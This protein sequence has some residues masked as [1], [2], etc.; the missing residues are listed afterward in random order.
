MDRCLL[1]LAVAIFAAVEGPLVFGLRELRDPAPTTEDPAVSNDDSLMP[2]TAVAPLS[3]DTVAP[4]ATVQLAAFDGRQGRRLNVAASMQLPPSYGP[5]ASPSPLPS[6]PLPPSPVEGN[7]PSPLPSTPLPPT[8]GNFSPSPV[9]PAPSPIPPPPPSPVMNDEA[10][11]P[12]PIPPP[13]PSP[14]MNDEAPAPS[15]LP[16]S[17]YVKDTPFPSSPTP[18][19]PPPF[20]LDPSEEPSPPSPQA[21]SPPVQASPVPSP[22]E[23]SPEPASPPAPW[24]TVPPSPS[25]AP[26]PAPSYPPSYPSSYP[27][28]YSPSPVP[29][30]PPTSSHSPSPVP[31][32]SPDPSSNSS[33]PSPSPSSSDTPSASYSPSPSPPVAS[34]SPSDAPS[35]SD[36]PFPSPSPSSPTSVLSNAP[37]C[38][39]DGTAATC[40]KTNATTGTI[41][42]AYLL[43]AS[44]WQ[45]VSSSYP[46]LLYEF[47]VISIIGSN[48]TY[49]A[50]QAYSTKSTATITSLPAGGANT[51][52]VC[53]RA[54][55][56]TTIPVGDRACALVT[57]KAST[58]VSDQQITSSI[59]AVQQALSSSS[60]V[61][62]ADSLDMAQRLSALATV[63]N[64]STVSA[65]ASNL[66]SQML[67]A[68]VNSDL[69]S[70]TASQVFGGMSA[71]WSLSSANGRAAVLNSV[72]SLTAKIAQLQLTPD[73]AGP[74]AGFF[75]EMLDNASELV[76]TTA[77][78]L[79][80]A[81]SAASIKAAQ[82]VLGTLVQGGA[83]LTQGLLNAAPADGSAISIST[84]RLSAAVRH[85]SVA[86][87]SAG[88]TTSF[89]A[90]GVATASSQ[91]RR[92]LL[93]SDF[94][95]SS[96]VTV[97][98]SPA[99][100]QLCAAVASCASSA[101]FGLTVRILD[102]TSLLI[103]SLGGSAVPLAANL[104]NRRIGGSVEI[105]SP[106]VRISAPGLPASASTLPSL[107]VLD[108]PV[109]MTAIAVNG[110]NTTRALVRLQDVGAASVDSSVG[111]FSGTSATSTLNPG[112]SGSTVPDVISGYSNS[113]GDFVVLQY[114]SGAVLTSGSSSSSPSPSPSP[115]PAHS[116]A[117]SATQPH[118][119]LACVLVGLVT[120]LLTFL[121]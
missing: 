35:A 57:V 10:P 78:G 68:A 12:S 89:H 43:S 105:I 3:H 121:S 51:L 118:T 41:L 16:P 65:L 59:L 93:A 77:A 13:P 86:L 69:S 84:T 81:S 33:S 83:A 67:N 19:S 75:S 94:S 74:I 96:P 119:L 60:A 70:A 52:Y 92:S 111:I 46:I 112:A 21:P 32:P 42:D 110:A 29:S 4:T 30:Y 2:L 8:E 7:T 88:I 82:Q 91:R 61:S 109:N 50:R 48:T 103:A 100:G 107:V 104:A 20:I 97:A 34:P 17:P 120:L 76:S 113:L 62:V 64:S 39:G 66:L 28:S 14:V 101:G 115:S 54:A 63:A 22:T 38:G 6:M 72:G 53:V 80:G 1:L 117:G 114:A 11:A 15:P 106:I 102:D 95:T 85:A 71:M 36:S 73:A 90:P 49:K 27:P 44:G 98:L 31:S 47:G 58:Q 25:P 116:A 5:T 56:S 23:Q 18:S 24:P 37:V 108:L 55:N 26:S 40:L 9:P 87:A 79:G 99:V 45:S